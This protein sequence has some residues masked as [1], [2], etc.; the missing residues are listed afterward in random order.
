MENNLIDIVSKYLISP[1][2]IKDMNP[3]EISRAIRDAMREYGKQ[4]FESG[5]KTSYAVSSTAYYDRGFL[6]FK[7]Y[8]E[9]EKSLKKQHD[10]ER[11]GQRIGG[12]V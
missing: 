4:C 10:R 5:R 6:T 11:K 9:Y 12:K 8:E 1:D 3:S 7:S 2:A